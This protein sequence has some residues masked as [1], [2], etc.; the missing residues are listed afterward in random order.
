MIETASRPSQ[1]SLRRALRRHTA[2]ERARRIILAHGWNATAYQLLDPSL[3]LWFSSL[4]DGV[5][6]FVRRGRTRVV[7]GA[8]VCAIERL[9]EITQ[10]WEREVARSGDVVCYFAAGHRLERLLSQRAKVLL[11]AQPVWNP[12][13]WHQHI[14]QHA[15]LRTQL[16]RA[17]NKGVQIEEWTTERAAQDVGLRHCLHHWLSRRGMPSLHF[18]AEPNVLSRLLDRRIWV[19]RIAHEAQAATIMGFCV[20]APVP[21]RHGW[22]L[23]HVIRN[24]HAPNGTAELLVDAAMRSVA[25][26]GAEY[27][28][29][30]LTPLCEVS[31]CSDG[32]VENRNP[33][34]LRL[35]LRWVRAHG[36]RFYNFDG[37]EAF[38]TKFR[39]EAWEPIYAISSEDTFSLRLL[40]AIAGAFTAQPPLRWILR[41]SLHAARQ[42]Q[43]W[44]LERRQRA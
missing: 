26:S 43:R 22:L 19:A 17:R 7:A 21:A 37:I 6:G 1:S 33:L 31:H 4:G 5:V 14:S 34:W 9:S 16:Q 40:F 42:E 12:T 35:A 29:L 24:A 25:L 36:R 15:S 30:G 13:R 18:L 10:E 8:P 41:T 3:T 23:E 20:A 2:C 44:W 27:V 28:T 39:P 32:P 38:K 11:G